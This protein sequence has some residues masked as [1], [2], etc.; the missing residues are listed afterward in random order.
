ML[1]SF[2]DLQSNF[3]AIESGRAQVDFRAVVVSDT[4]ENFD[5]MEKSFDCVREE[6]AYCSW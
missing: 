2:H 4:P 3:I 5:G 1:L 6:G